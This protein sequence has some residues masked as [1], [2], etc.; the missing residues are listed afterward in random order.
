MKEDGF[1]LEAHRL[2]TLHADSVASLPL[3]V[4]IADS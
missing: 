3:V 2:N 1:L 4:I